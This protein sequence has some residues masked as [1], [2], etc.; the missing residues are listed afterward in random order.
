MFTLAILAAALTAAPAC[1][2]PTPSQP[3]GNYLTPG[4]LGD[5][6]YKDDLKLDAYAPENSPRPAVVIIH[7]SYG[8]KRTHITQ[9]LEPL[10][11][12]NVDWFSIDYRTLED[13]E[14]AVRF[15][16]CPGRFNITNAMFVIGEDTGGEIAL[17]LAARGKFQG[18]ATFGLKLS[19]QFV[20]SLSAEQPQT[21]RELPSISVQMFHSTEDDESPLA[22]VQTL[23]KAMPKCVLHAVPGGI[24]QFENWH[25]D[26]WS[27][28]EDLT[29]WLRGDGPGLWKDI[30]YARP[31]G[32]DLL[33][34]AFLPEGN[35]PFPA[36]ILIHGG[37]WEAGDKVTYVSPVFEPLARS[38]VAWFSIDYRLT[39]YVRV[40]DQLDDVR[41]AIRYVRQHA[42]R[43]H[44]DANRL[45][46]IGESASGHLVAQV[47]SEPCPD[48][49]VQAVVSF[50]GVYDFTHW[51]NGEEWQR[52]AVTRLFGDGA[53]DAATRFSPIEHITSSLPPIL[54]IQGTKDELYPGTLDYAA[55]LKKAGAHYE[56]VLLEGAPHGMENWEDHPEWAFYKKKLTDWLWTV[57]NRN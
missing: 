30:V 14:E 4:V 11:R 6:I 25:P 34:D 36:A 10:N 32:R 52:Q 8:N 15:I 45:A 20:A 9:L 50:Y 46:L 37:G 44:I 5:V 35:G 38:R 1:S 27:W 12:A 16:R 53:P 24:H 51:S 54:L 43:F 40:S 49:N 42:D 18:V 29:A 7:G 57:F 26:Q 22:Q 23:C 56:L 47:A 2:K 3:Y 28:K 17:E 13:V 19:P 48:C 33:M 41:S 55:R 21:R 31:G 39:P